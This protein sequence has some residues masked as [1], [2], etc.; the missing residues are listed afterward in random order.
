MNICVTVKAKL[1]II[2][3][4]IYFTA[5]DTTPEPFKLYSVMEMGGRL[6]K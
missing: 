3:E 1:I 6:S 2:I 5:S 4:Q